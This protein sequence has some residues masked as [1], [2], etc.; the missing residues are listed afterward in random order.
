MT[1]VIIKM[2]ETR[3]LKEGKKKED[4]KNSE[5]F[6]EDIKKRVKW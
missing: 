6:N 4:F 1:G 5:N 3:E 2:N